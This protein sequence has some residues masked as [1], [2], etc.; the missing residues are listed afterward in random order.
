MIKEKARSTRSDKKVDCKPTISIH[1]KETVNRLSYITNKPVKDVGE[2]ICKFGLQSRK[3]IE[4]LSKHFRRDFRIGNTYY[5]GDLERTSLQRR[6]SKARMDRIT[7]RFKQVDYERIKVLA[8]ALDVTP[9]KATALLLELS[10]HNTNFINR[11]VKEYIKDSLDEGRMKELQQVIRYINKNSPYDDKVSWAT[12]FSYL[13]DELKLGASNM[14]SALS[15]WL[16]RN[17]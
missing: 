1:L 10:I 2:E 16:D 8:Y 9:T 14:S 15:N 13:V 5:M 4:L 6:K 17:K 12:L 3:V 7:I 11:F